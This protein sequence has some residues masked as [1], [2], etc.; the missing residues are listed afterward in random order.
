MKLHGLPKG[1]DRKS[2]D[3]YYLEMAELISSRATC[4]RM[5]CGAVVVN[6][7]RIISTG[8]NGSVRGEPHCDDVGHWMEDNHCIRTIHAEAN[9]LLFADRSDANGSTVYINNPPCARCQNLMRQAGVIRC[10]WMEWHG[11][12]YEKR[13]VIYGVRYH[14]PQ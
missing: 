4:D 14:L 8:Y 3:S 7:G 10:V 2:W 6:D 5:H 13:E 12:D 9:A 1:S 11:A